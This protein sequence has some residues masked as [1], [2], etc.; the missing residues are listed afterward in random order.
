M[1]SSAVKR[2]TNNRYVC[3]YRGHI[4][5]QSIWPGPCSLVVDI[6]LQIQGYLVWSLIGVLNGNILFTG[7]FL[8]L[9]HLVTGAK[10]ITI[11]AQGLCNGNNPKEPWNSKK[12]LIQMFYCRME[13]CSSVLKRSTNN[14][15]VCKYIGCIIDQ[16]IW[17]GPFS[18]VVMTLDYR[19]R[20]TQFDP[21][22]EHSTGIFSL[23]V[24]F[25]SYYSC[26]NWKDF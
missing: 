14:R 2:S 8:F 23:H 3:K 13:E 10:M 6:R 17:S 1:C 4:T 16:S 20:G 24:C 25:S 7:L 11:R 22:L 5:D 18:L 15:Y 26:K 19:S 9:L 12:H 21:W